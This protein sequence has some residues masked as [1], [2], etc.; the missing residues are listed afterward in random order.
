MSLIVL[1]GNVSP[2]VRKVRVVLAEKGIEH[3]HEQVNPFSPPP[4]FRSLSP[5]GKIPVLKDGD[6]T[7]CDSSV[8]CAYLEKRFPTPALYPSDPYEYARTLWIEEF[9]DGGVVSIGGPKIFVPLVIQ[10][11]LS[12][13]Q[14]PSA[15]AEEVA[16]KAWSEGVLPLLTYLETELGDRETF[17]GDGLTLADISVASHLVNLRYAGFVADRGR[18]PRLRAFLDRMWA[19]PSFKPLIE[20]D[21]PMFGKRAARL[22]D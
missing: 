17:V 16:R 1:G 10:P 18:Y 11:L 8:I 12:G 9:M 15:E 21:L 13:G 19:R 7:L 4:N 3:Q 5:L 22:D 20:A 2:F 6:R 14:G